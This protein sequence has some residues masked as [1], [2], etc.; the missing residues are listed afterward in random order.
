MYKL[1]ESL[2]RRPEK[3]GAEMASGTFKRELD[4]NCY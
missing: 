3:P 4:S 1:K 2:S